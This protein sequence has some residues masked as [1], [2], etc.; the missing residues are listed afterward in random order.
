MR[1]YIASLKKL[2]QREDKIFWPGH[3]GPVKKPQAYA[4]AL[5]R[6]RREREE[7]VLACVRAGHSAI[8]AIAAKVY[9]GLD[10]RLAPAAAHSV[11]ARIK[12]LVSRGLVGAEGAI[13]LGSAFYPV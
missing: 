7:A 4:G 10:P 11:L 5:I 12:D 9:E 8:P 3:S 13:T 1:D 6:H 2:W